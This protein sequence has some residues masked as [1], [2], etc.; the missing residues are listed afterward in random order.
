VDCG[1]EGR[2]SLCWKV[3]GESKIQGLGLYSGPPPRLSELGVRVAH[4]D[5]DVVRWKYQLSCQ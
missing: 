5:T 2:L 1:I 3:C 4:P